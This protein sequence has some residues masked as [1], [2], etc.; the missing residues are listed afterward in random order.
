METNT[1]ITGKDLIKLGYRQGKWMKDTLVYINKNQLQGDALQ[2]YLEQYKL[3]DPLPL[4]SKPLDFSIL[5]LI[6]STCIIF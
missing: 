4:H 3:P 1:R 2:S 5:S 6:G